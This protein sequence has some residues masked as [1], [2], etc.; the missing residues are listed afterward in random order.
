MHAV[1]NTTLG[2]WFVSGS[3]DAE[4]EIAAARETHVLCRSGTLLT[5]FL[6]LSVLGCLGL[7]GVQ[8]WPSPW[9]KG[10]LRAE[11]GCMP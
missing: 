6:H 1:P 9:V 2:T 5:S 8:N 11:R 7:E 3:G 4:S 10:E